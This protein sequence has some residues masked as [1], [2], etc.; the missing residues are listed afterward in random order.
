MSNDLQYNQTSS[1]LP[2]M[3]IRF[4]MD[5]DDDL[6]DFR[7]FRIGRIEQVNDGASIAT[8]RAL[9]YDLSETNETG[10]VVI[11]AAEHCVERSLD[12]IAR[13][14]VLPDSPFQSVNNPVLW[15]RVLSAC[16]DNIPPGALLDYFVQI[17]GVVQRMS[18]ASL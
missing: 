10:D 3:I 12:Q 14:R 8:I 17:D 15:G 16:Q 6:A 11:K 4:P 2:G 13:C 9:I 5:T 18:E 7:E 1:L